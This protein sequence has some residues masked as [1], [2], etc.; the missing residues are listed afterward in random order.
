MYG[1]CRP[2]H[3]ASFGVENDSFDEDFPLVEHMGRET[4]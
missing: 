2:F 1:K 3:A 4:F